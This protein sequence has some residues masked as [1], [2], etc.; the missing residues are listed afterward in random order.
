M[1]APQR[2]ELLTEWLRFYNEAIRFGSTHPEDVAD[3]LAFG[4]IQPRH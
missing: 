2:A 1:S 3:V 4:T